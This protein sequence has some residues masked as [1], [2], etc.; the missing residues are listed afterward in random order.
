MDQGNSLARI[1][2]TEAVK[3]VWASKATI[4]RRIKEGKL[5]LHQ[6]GS[7]QLLDVADLIRVFG[8]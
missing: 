6:E 8:E 1:T 7:Q 4:Y 2:V 3:A 5:Q